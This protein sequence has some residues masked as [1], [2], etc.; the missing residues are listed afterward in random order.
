[1]AAAAAAAPLSVRASVARAV[2]VPELVAESR[3]VVLGA[4][5]DSFAKKERIGRRE[6]I[7]TYS[8]FQVEEPLAGSEPS[9]AEL[10]VRTLGGTLGTVG[11]LFHGE[12]VVALHRRA[13]L[14]L[15]EAGTELFAV[16][17]M[18]QGH[19]PVEADQAGVHRLHAA[20]DAV[21]LVGDAESAMR[22]LH[23]LRVGEAR[24][25]LRLEAA[26]GAR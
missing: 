7:V 17:A 11:Q 5:V 24:E 13:T 8:L 4:A 15:R 10:M 25:L 19:Y 23:G 14:F 21:H 16:T 26:R 3:H 1:M 6:C 20:F 22:R 9:T 2:T 18:A 12:A